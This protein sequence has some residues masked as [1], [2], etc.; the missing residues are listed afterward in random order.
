MTLLKKSFQ[1]AAYQYAGLASTAILGFFTSVYLIKKLT[2]EEYGIY[3]FLWSLVIVANLITAFGITQAIQRYLPEYRQ[4]N[5]IYVQK[6]IIIGS[7]LL[8]FLA[9][10]LFVLIFLVSIDKLLLVFNI[11]HAW[12]LCVLASLL[13]TFFNVESKLLGDGALPAMLENRYLNIINII[14]KAL[15]LGLFALSIVLGYGLY[16]IVL[17]WLIIEVALFLL[18]F[19]KVYRKI[20]CLP[21]LMSKVNKNLPLKRFMSFS[22]YVYLANIAYFFTDRSADIFLLSYFIGPKAVGLYSF[23]FGI[24]LTIMRLSPASALRSLLTPVVVS[25]YAATK[26]NKDLVYFFSFI[27]RLTFFTMVPLFLSFMILSDGIIK[28]VFNVSYLENKD[29]FILSLFFVTLLQFLYSYSSIIYTL[30]K[31]RLFLIS[32]LFGGLNLIGD[33]ILIPIYG[34]KGAVLATGVSGI[35]LI[36]VFHIIIKRGLNISYPWRSFTRFGLNILAMCAV[37]FALKGLPNGIF[38]LVCVFLTGLAVY[39]VASYFNKGFEKKDREL[40]NRGIGREIWVF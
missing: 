17:A 3:N 29:L 22:G 7:M 20:L 14:C 37:L 11:P 38:S 4:K 30:E 18:Y 34:A 32:I 8:R 26:S 23:A 21:V 24:P 28:Y 13:I 40:I 16:G 5:D 35:A 19:Y 25:R 27:S 15:Q 33:I 36:V 12:K 6:N 1:G 31:K 2:I 9:D 39:I 10:V